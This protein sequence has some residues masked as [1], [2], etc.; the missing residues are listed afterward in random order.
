MAKRSASQTY[1]SSEKGRSVVKRYSSSE[2]RRSAVKRYSSS[3]KGR[4]VVKR[5]SSSEKG[6]KAYIMAAQRYRSSEQGK[7][8]IEDWLQRNESQNILKDLKK[9][10]RGK[11]GRETLADLERLRRRALAKKALKNSRLQIQLQKKKRMENAA[12][13][14]KQLKK[15]RNDDTWDLSAAKADPKNKEAHEIIRKH[16]PLTQA[17]KDF[18]TH[19]QIIL[20]DRQKVFL[21]RLPKSSRLEGIKARMKGIFRSRAHIQQRSDINYTICL[22]EVIRER[23]QGTNTSQLKTL[24]KFLNLDDSGAGRVNKHQRKEVVTDFVKKVKVQRNTLVRWIA[25]KFKKLK[26]TAEEILARITSKKVGVD[27]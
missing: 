9:K 11:K 18:F 4:S 15:I 24:M 12:A 7:K 6:H 16:R 20:K 8:K 22:T 26:Y 14:Q 19:R 13:Y 25:T 2:K 27:N 21:P 1:S 23:V 17:C 10:Y 3:E 5:Y